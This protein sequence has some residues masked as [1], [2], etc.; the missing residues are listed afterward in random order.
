MIDYTP[1]QK[2]EQPRFATKYIS[3]PKR[4]TPVSSGYIPRVTQKIG[5]LQTSGG[6]TALK[7]PKKYTGDKMIGIT[8]LHKS[9]LQPVFSQQEAEDA[10]S[11]RR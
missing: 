11:M 10:A 1:K 6:S 2:K 3:S 8:I 7:E 4:I 5:S 9:C